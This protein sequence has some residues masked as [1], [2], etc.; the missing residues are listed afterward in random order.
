[1]S[2][3]PGTV[4]ALLEAL[5]RRADDGA[6]LDV[7]AV[8][9]A[10]RSPRIA[11]WIRRR[12]M[13]YTC[14]WAGRLDPALAGV[15][16]YLV[17]LHRREPLTRELLE[18]MWGDSWGVFAA[19]N[20]TMEQLRVHFR[21]FLRVRDERGRRLLFRWYDPRVLRVYLPSCTPAEL[22]QVFGPVDRLFAE[23]DGAA[24]LLAFRRVGGA[25][26][27]VPIPVVPDA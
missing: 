2:A 17:H 5:F 11:P 25:L 8:L 27:A 21:R 7:Y 22:A 10:A 13:D 6:P 4:D 3:A 16:P 20:A 26:D 1:V 19:A 12:A 9:D 18:L 23:A 14:L 24:E 15:A